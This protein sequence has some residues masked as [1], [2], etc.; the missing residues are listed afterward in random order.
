MSLGIGGS[1]TKTSDGELFSTGDACRVF[2]MHIISGSSGGVVSLKDGGSSGTTRI[3]ETGQAGTG[4]TFSYPGGKRF[5][6]G[7]YVDLDSNVTSV[8][9]ETIK[10]L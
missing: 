9:I 4:K 7:C 2:S 1:I 5:N 6:S 8:D 3:Q 10:E